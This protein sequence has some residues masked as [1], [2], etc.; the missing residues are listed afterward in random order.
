MKRCLAAITILCLALSG[1]F[2]QSVYEPGI[3]DH[4]N[5]GFKVDYVC[6]KCGVTDISPHGRNCRLGGKCE[7]VRGRR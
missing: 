3:G 7:W 1:A 4:P 5:S 2:A 6:R